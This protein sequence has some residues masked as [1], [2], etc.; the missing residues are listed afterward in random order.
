[1]KRRTKY[2]RTKRKAVRKFKIT[3]GQKLND[4]ALKH[5]RK[6]WK[7]IKPYC[8]RKSRK[9]DNLN[10]KDMFNLFQSMFG[11]DFPQDNI[12]IPL[13]QNIFDH[14]LDADISLEELKSAVFHQKN[15]S[16]CG[17]DNVCSETVKSSFDIIGSLL[18]NI[19]NEIFHTRVYP[20]P[21]GRGIIAPIF[22]N[23]DEHLA[24]NY[25]GI[26]ISNVF[27]K[28]Y[29]QILLTRLTKW[30]E[31]HEVLS[32]NQFGFQKGKST[33]DCIF[34]FHSIITKVL[35]S[36]EKLYCLFIDLEKAFD[37]IDRFVLWQK[38][39]F[40]NVSSKMVRSNN[41]MYT[42]VKYVL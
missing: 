31:R 34:I 10:M 14:E 29:S 27:S 26:T 11:E 22:K 4:A 9:G 8:K 2:N 25:R 37:R 18:L 38:L 36:K 19:M 39:I 42:Y 40:Q 41:A 23:K 13:N 35:S 16:S 17:L 20:E 30:S 21:W 6:F 1:M 15:N 12:E 33:A 5:P 32:N 3:E 7:K 24:K 28:I